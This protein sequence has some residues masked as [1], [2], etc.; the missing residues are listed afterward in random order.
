MSALV[1]LTVT[2]KGKQKFVGKVGD[3]RSEKLKRN[4]RLFYREANFGDFF[5]SKTN[6]F[7]VDKSAADYAAKILKAEFMAC[8]CKDTKDLYV[9]PTA[10]FAG[11]DVADLGE[12]PQY[13]IP[14]DSLKKYADHKPITLGFTK[15]VIKVK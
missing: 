6:S 8:F 11:A 3:Y 14:F 5:S 4:I 7:G 1:G 13:R 15:T 10:V 12:L 2:V 9:V